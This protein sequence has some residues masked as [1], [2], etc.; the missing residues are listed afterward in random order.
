VDRGTHQAFGI[1][2]NVDDFLN[3]IVHELKALTGK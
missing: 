3:R 2:R 1:V